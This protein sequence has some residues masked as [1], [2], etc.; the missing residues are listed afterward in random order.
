M[1]QNERLK[2]LR[3]S[4]RYTHQE[5]AELLD[6]STPQIW[7]YEA[8]KVDPSADVLARLAMVFSVSTDYLLGLTEDPAPSPLS[9]NNLTE[10]EHSVVAALRRGEKYEAIRLIVTE[11]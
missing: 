4:K 10:H 9:E 3:E 5:L 8:G 6:I 1:L 2:N 11:L 7:R